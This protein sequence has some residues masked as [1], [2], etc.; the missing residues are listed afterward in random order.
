M[1][2]ERRRAEEDIGRADGILIWG[3]AFQLSYPTRDQPR[4]CSG[5]SDRLHTRK[6]YLNEA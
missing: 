3:E 5:T 4:D 6:A 2:V 1:G